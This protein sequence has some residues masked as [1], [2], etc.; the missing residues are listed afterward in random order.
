MTVSQVKFS[1]RLFID[2]GLIA[3]HSLRMPQDY[4]SQ[5]FESLD[6]PEKFWGRQGERIQWIKKPN[7]ILSKY[8]NSHDRWFEGGTLNTCALALDYHVNSGRADQIALIYDSPVTGQKE[9]FT[10]TELLKQTALL[11]GALVDLGITRGDRVIIYMPMIPQAVM[12]MLA[13]A[14][15]GAIHS[16]VFGGFAPHELALRIDDAEPKIILTASCGIEVSQVIPYQPLVNRA[17]EEAKHKPEKV[18]LFQRKQHQATLGER[19]LDWALC[20]QKAKPAAALELNAWDPL[21]ILYTSGTTGKPKGII[22]DNGGHAVALKYSMSE[23]FNMQPGEVFWAASDVGWVVGHSYIVYAPLIHGCTTLLYEGKPIKTP[24]AGA[25]WRVAAE[26]NVKSLFCAPTALRA[27]RKEDA[28]GSLIELN[29]P[30]KLQALF[31]AGERL[32]TSTYEWA[33]S[34]LNVPVIDNWWQTETGWPIVANMMGLEPVATKPGSAT[35]PV[36]GYA[37]KIL[38][39]EGE[40]LPAGREGAVAI[41]LPLPPGC[42]YTLWK[43][44]ARFH[45]GYLEKFPG[46]YVSGDG[47]LIDQDGYVFLLGRID[48]VINVA[49]HRLST[50]EMEELVTQNPVVAECAVFGVEDEIKG[51][52]PLALIVL[53]EKVTISE[54]ELS[55]ELVALV[56]E[57]I[58]AVACFKTALVVKRLPKTRSGKILR[59][60]LRKIADQQPFTVPSTIED[61]AVLEEIQNKLQLALKQTKKT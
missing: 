38:S 43:D 33:H 42:L 12:A 46:Y 13:C 2:P 57:K 59:A 30:K 16:V 52:I 11:A 48:D 55:R 9:K 5:Y 10:Y 58:G 34:K 60:T 50:A 56:R 27:I 61:P 22:R 45:K 32:D 31:V 28:N 51:Q 21:Y 41:Q 6:S 19:D 17:I 3:F 1:H 26:Y 7:K 44:D 18:L 29:R 24:D 54:Q 20:T 53:K 36:C 40:V 8:P 37:V 4:K 49:G 39:E 23:I 14:R 25:F 47:G 35:R 15:I